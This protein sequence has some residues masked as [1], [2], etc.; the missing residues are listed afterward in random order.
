MEVS[1]RP[2]V[3]VYSGAADGE[4]DRELPAFLRLKN[5]RS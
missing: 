1:V 3:P 5:N 4:D 2:S